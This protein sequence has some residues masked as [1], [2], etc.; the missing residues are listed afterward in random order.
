MAQQYVTD[1]GTLIIPAAYARWKVQAENFGL[2]ANGIL[3]LVGEADAG[4][5]YT[6]EDNLQ[7]NMFGPDEMAAVVTKYRSGNLVDAF[8]AALNASTD[9]AIVGA[10]N[11]IILVKTNNS[12]RATG[13][14][15]DYDVDL[16]ARNHGTFGN[17]I[18][19]EVEQ[20]GDGSVTT[21]FTWVD[22][23][24]VDIYMRFNGSEAY[25]ASVTDVASVVAAIDGWTVGG[26]T[27]AID[28]EVPQRVILTLDNP[29]PGISQSIAFEGWTDDWTAEGITTRLVTPS[30]EESVRLK[31]GRD[32]IEEEHIAGGEVGLRISCTQD[33][34][35]V[36]I[37]ET[38]LRIHDGVDDI[39][40]VSLA[41]YP[42]ISALAQ[43]ISTHAD[44]Y[45]APG[46]VVTASLPPSVLD[47]GTDIPIEGTEHLLTGRI[48]TDARDFARAVNNH[49]TL[50][51]LGDPASRVDAG[52]PAPQALTYMTGG[53]RGTTEMSDIV[54]ALEALEKVRGN[55][56]V[57]LFSR[58]SSKDVAEKVTDSDSSYNIDAINLLVR[59]HVG[60]MSTMKRRRNRQAFLS[61][62]PTIEVDSPG[63]FEDQQ[64]AAGTIASFRCSMAFQRVRT[65]GS[66]GLVRQFPSWMAAVKAAAMQATGLYRALVAK[67]T[68]ITGIYHDSFD[69]ENDSQTERALL[70]GLLPLRQR[71]DG[72]YYW[73]SDQT[74]YS[75][76]ENFV[77]NSIQAVYVA[78][79][80]A[81]TA[82]R[83]MER[84]FVGKS[85]AEISATMAR[86]F[87][88]NQV[89]DPMRGLRL[90]A[91]SD[92]APLGYKD[93]S[94]RIAGPVMFVSFEVKLAG[95]IYFIPINF[96]ISA[97]QQEAA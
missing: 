17:Q 25:T 52:L 3:M 50:V 85:Q 13:G 79:L 4:P 49:S 16:F 63:S 31:V 88:M 90:I 6:E 94:V 77:F 67:T 27:A 44:C 43:Y 83:K 9:P 37:S 48:K 82:I 32:Q 65:L 84:A 15:A 1:A 29:T 45:A 11:G 72:A 46:S 34:A 75:R 74:T 19:F 41:D 66:G 60:A 39:L 2:A 18:H 33:D 24:G 7:S 80:I 64:E 92:D 81:L 97:V 87:L 14:L 76:D 22:Q 47:R 69:P 42:T 86:A 62:E 5:Q 59:N 71:E 95:A 61:R 10:P 68:A 53:T 8:Y 36:D 58:N 56:I 30:A 21:S 35:L 91:P 93:V 55:F 40:V 96:M 54:G 89:L 23:G 51:Q 26:L 70:S 12:T 38:Q 20:V 57:P 28:S 78:D 73:V